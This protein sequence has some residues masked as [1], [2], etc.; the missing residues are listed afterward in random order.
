MVSTTEEIL[1]GGAGQR[2]RTDT[3]YKGILP[4]PISRKMRSLKWRRK[5]QKASGEIRYVALY[6]F[7]EASRLG[8]LIFVFGRQRQRVNYGLDTT[9]EPPTRPAPYEARSTVS[10]QRQSDASD[11]NSFMLTSRFFSAAH[12]ITTANWE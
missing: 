8:V 1:A 2:T 6:F 11:Q 10:G 7:C 12:A 5:A 4:C 3:L 9:R